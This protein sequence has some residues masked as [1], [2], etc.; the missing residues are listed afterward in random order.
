LFAI[1]QVA[2]QE[3]EVPLPQTTFTDTR[4]LCLATNHALG[5]W[6]QIFYHPLKEHLEANISVVS[7]ATA[8]LRG[9]WEH[10]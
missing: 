3:L 2:Q 6:W 8:V 10:N 7:Y 4:K 1:K 5:E 9:H